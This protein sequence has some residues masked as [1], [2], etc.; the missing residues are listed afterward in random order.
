MTSDKAG[1]MGDIGDMGVSLVQKML[2]AVSG[3]VLTSL[4]GTLSLII[5]VY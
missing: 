2:S 3:S 1:E 5:F 4:L